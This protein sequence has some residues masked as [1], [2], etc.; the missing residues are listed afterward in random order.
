M[1]KACESLK[2]DVEGVSYIGSDHIDITS[3]GKI[4]SNV[5]DFTCVTV[6]CTSIY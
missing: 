4:Y 6:V 2:L 5:F 3:S 1:S